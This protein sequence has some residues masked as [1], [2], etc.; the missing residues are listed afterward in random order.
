MIRF[1]SVS[2]RKAK[3]VDELCRRSSRSDGC[4]YVLEFRCSTEMNPVSNL[5]G[6][7]LAGVYVTVICY[8]VTV[9][10]VVESFFFEFYQF[11]HV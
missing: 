8:F 2:G 5:S 4:V 1:G 11:D 3:F 10:I 6:F 9:A 7:V